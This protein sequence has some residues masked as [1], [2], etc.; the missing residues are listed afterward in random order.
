[1]TGAGWVETDWNLQ[2][3]YHDAAKMQILVEG[4]L[5]WYHRCLS[6]GGGFDLQL[7]TCKIL[8]RLGLQKCHS[9]SP[10]PPCGEAYERQRLLFSTRPEIVSIGEIPR[11]SVNGFW[12]LIGRRREALNNFL[13]P[14]LADVYLMCNKS[15]TRWDVCDLGFG[16]PWC[17]RRFEM[18]SSSASLPLPHSVPF[19]FGSLFFI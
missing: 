11:C 1:M 5:N 2:L 3:R 17:S 9:L 12:Q 8:E 7:C 16:L 19:H 4:H 14:C 10:G 6:G 13:A 18:T 15:H